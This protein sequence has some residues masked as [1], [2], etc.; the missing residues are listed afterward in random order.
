MFQERLL[1][2]RCLH[3]GVSEMI[4]E[5]NSSISCECTRNASV[6]QRKE[7][8]G[9]NDSVGCDKP[10]QSRNL[11]PSTHGL[12]ARTA[13][14]LQKRPSKQDCLNLWLETTGIYSS[15]SLTKISD[16]PY[17]L[18]GLV[19]GFSEALMC[20]YLAGLWD[21]DLLR[22][23]L[24]RAVPGRS[25]AKQLNVPTWSWMS[26]CHPHT[27]ACSV[28]YS[29]SLLDEFYKDERLIIHHSSTFCH[30]LDNDIGR[31][32]YG[33]ID[34][35]GALRHCKVVEF[36]LDSYTELRIHAEISNGQRQSA[37]LVADCPTADGLYEDEELS[38]LLIGI[39]RDACGRSES[40]IVLRAHHGSPNYTRVSMAD[41]YGSWFNR[42]D[43][44]RIQIV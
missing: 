40:V 26:H 15:L 14:V 44:K 19:T 28:Y 43:T 29:K 35:S 42:T 11:D 22:A 13:L 16:R 31:V 2:P 36:K 25:R 30:Y 17:A 18:A 32:E 33:Q 27:N 24:W 41:I 37:R 4:W 7:L 39:S 23:L 20:N 6:S 12:K 21:V 34:V 5:C 1:A 38:C 10:S 9:R 8:H 3:F